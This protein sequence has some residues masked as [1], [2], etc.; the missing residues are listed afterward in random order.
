MVRL[1]E[2]GA[3]EH[4]Q[5]HGHGQAQSYGASANGLPTLTALSNEVKELVR[6]IS[7]TDIN[8]LHLESGAVRIVIKRGGIAAA[9][10]YA[11]PAVYTPPPTLTTPDRSESVNLIGHS[12][13]HGDEV[14]LEEGEELIVAPMVGTFYAAPAP[15]EPPYV[16]EGLDIEPST[17][18]GII[19][20]MKMMNEIEAEVGGRIVRILVQNAEPV[21]YGQPLMVVAT[22]G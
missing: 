21:E 2:K 10:A 12:P 6:L 13:T 18:V 5:E 15:N 9:P 16:T 11:P 14:A 19:E 1:P 20:A 22:N 7:A 3:D 8:E 17:V 4:E